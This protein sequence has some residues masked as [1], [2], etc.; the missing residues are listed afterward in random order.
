MY[1]IHT[2]FAAIMTR[3]LLYSTSSCHYTLN[4]CYSNEAGAA[5]TA[6]SCPLMKCM[7]DSA[8]T[9]YV[10]ASLLYMS[11]AYVQLC[12][13]AH[14]GVCGMVHHSTTPHTVYKANW[15]ESETELQQQVRAV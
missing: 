13:R 9:I 10:F 2:F 11:C 14:V 3:R 6:D 5:C 15:S 7:R 8:Y 4:F 1:D 12:V